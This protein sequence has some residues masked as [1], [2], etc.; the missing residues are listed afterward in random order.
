MHLYEIIYRKDG[1]YQ[2]KYQYALIGKANSLE[3]AREKRKVSGDIVVWADTHKVVQDPTW[4][5]EWE[6]QKQN[7]SYAYRAHVQGYGPKER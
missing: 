6:K 3:E 7:D 2:G 4:L 1:P 5:W